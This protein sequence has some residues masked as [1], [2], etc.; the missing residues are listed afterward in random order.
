M[1]VYRWDLDK[2]YL[3][4]DFQSFRG[5]VRIATEPAHRKRALPGATALLRA[6]SQQNDARVTVISGSP[7]QMQGV[8]SEKLA[9]DGIR[10]DELVLKD[11]LGN[12]R[13]GRIRALRGQLGYKLPALLE[14][15]GRSKS[16]AVEVLFG[17]D[18]ESD[19]LAYSVY[20]DAI[21]RKIGPAEVSRIMETAGAYPDEVDRAL[22]ALVSIRTRHAVERIFIRQERGVPSNRLA[23]L[24]RRVVPIRSWWQAGI[25]LFEMG[26]LSQSDLG[27]VMESVYES[28]GRD[29]WPMAAL[30]QDM[31]RRG[32]VKN[33]T[34][35]QV[36]GPT[37][38]ID[39]LMVSVRSL[40]GRGVQ[41]TP[42]CD[43]S[44]DYLALLKS[45]AWNSR[46]QAK[47]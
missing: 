18:V 27:S 47:R 12:V 1:K 10:V 31:L 36:V 24:G 8:L 15:R 6:L 37:E 38:L 33:Q 28:E 3:D 14:A 13:R 17:D 45:D 32:W 5:L 44:I 35:E 20:A 7:T 11:N 34:L 42:A 25:V 16:A 2:T 19:A 4:T 39:A 9:M 23:D 30:A 41:A 40:S 46:G 43:D 21:S 29:P 26:H 22:E